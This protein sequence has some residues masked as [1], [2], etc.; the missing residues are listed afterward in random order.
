[1]DSAPSPPPTSLA[2][3]LAV[4]YCWLAWVQRLANRAFIPMARIAS[5]L[6]RLCFP[7]WLPVGGWASTFLPGRAVIASVMSVVSIITTDATSEDRRIYG[8]NEKQIAR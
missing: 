3:R 4:T 5:E 7:S 1:L 6:R 8:W 2:T